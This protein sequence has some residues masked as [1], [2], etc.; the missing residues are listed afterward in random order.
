MVFVCISSSI[1]F[2]FHFFRRIFSDLSSIFFL[3]SS[4][5]PIQCSDLKPYYYILVD[6]G[7]RI[8]FFF[9]NI[10]SSFFLDVPLVISPVSSSWSRALYQFS[11]S[12]ALYTIL[13]RELLGILK[14]HRPSNVKPYYYILLTM[15]FIRVVQNDMKKM[16][17]TNIHLHIAALV[18]LSKV[19]YHTKIWINRRR[20]RGPYELKV[21]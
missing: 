10:H 11:V 18:P 8:F 4:M 16:K 14:V 3:I 20:F 1:I 21:I 19:N 17:L 9:T 6:H 2:I 5:I 7:I 15:V 13:L 12:H